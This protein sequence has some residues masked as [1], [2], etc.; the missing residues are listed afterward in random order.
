LALV[1]IQLLL[2]PIVYKRLVADPSHVIG[3]YPN[4]LPQEYRNEL[5]YPDRVPEL[6]GIDLENGYLALIE[7]LTHV[8]HLIESLLF[9]NL[10]FQQRNELSKDMIND[11][12]S[13]AIVEGT[14][15]ITSK[16]QLS[17]IIDT[18]LLKCY[19][20]VSALLLLVSSLI[21]LL[22]QTNDALVAPLLRLK[23]NNCHIEESERVLKKHQ[24]YSELIILYEKKGQH[25]KGF[26]LL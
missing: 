25:R 15:T 13:S 1:C 19:I 20:H 12:V 3:L 10:Y 24:K 26:L 21:S 14:A 4:L 6:E 8:S 18:S 7:Y 5:E 23:D 11:L 9:L 17:Q 16:K 22:L 2:L